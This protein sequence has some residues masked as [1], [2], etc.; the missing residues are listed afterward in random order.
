MTRPKLT[1]SDLREI[2]Q[3]NKS[4]EVKALLWEI[5][6]LRSIILRADQLQRALGPMGGAQGMM[7]DSLRAEL[8]GEPCVDEFP[9]LDAD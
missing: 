4:P 2:G 7:L 9:R 6:R 3:R 8:E 5:H 1:R